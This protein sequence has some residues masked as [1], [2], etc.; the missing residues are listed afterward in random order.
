MNTVFHSISHFLHL[1]HPHAHHVYHESEEAKMARQAVRPAIALVSIG[2]AS[3]LA[4]CLDTTHFYEMGIVIGAVALFAAGI[5][6]LYR[7]F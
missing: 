4:Y 3:E 7:H 1:D 2:F 5:T 6:Y